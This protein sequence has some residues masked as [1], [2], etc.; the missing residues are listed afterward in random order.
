MNNMLSTIIQQVMNGSMQNNPM[1]NIF[2]EM[3]R[4]KDKRQ[5]IQTLLNSASSKGIDVNE[6]RFSEQDLK[7]LGLK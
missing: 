1:M 6:K 5:Q 2:N 7:M 4:G 3:M